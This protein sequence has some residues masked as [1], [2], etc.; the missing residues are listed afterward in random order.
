MPALALVLL[1]SAAP[2]PEAAVRAADVAL[3]RAV[4]S[5]DAGAFGA[6]LEE[7]ATFAGG[8]GLSRGRDAVLASWKPLLSPDGPRLRWAPS[9]AVVATSG[10]LAF[11]IG[12]WRL[13]AKGQEG[14]PVHE[15]GEYVTVWRRAGKGPW[16]V[17]LDGSL[18]PAAKLGEG[19]ARTPVLSAASAAGDLEAAIGTWT[20]GV[21]EGAYLSV[22]RRARSGA[23]EVAVD[24][25]F[26]FPRPPPASAQ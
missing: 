22:R 3:D 1:L 6:L 15:E 10:D 24:S 26:A 17:L 11:T 12:R 8:R 5:G 20:R 2:S 19:L 14:K 9:R 4:S 7:G 16:R 18:R 21:D 23:W 25:A 13:D